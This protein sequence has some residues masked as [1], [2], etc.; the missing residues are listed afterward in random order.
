MNYDIYFGTFNLFLQLFRNYIIKLP[1]T[2]GIMIA[3]F[4][5]RYYKYL[6]HLKII[7]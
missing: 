3:N 7:F 5:F 2:Q 1:D 6:P 4:E